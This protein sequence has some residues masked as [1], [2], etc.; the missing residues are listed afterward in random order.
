MNIADIT[1]LPA[2]TVIGA[3]M[4]ATLLSACA[5][6]PAPQASAPAIAAVTTPDPA[7]V[8]AE[9]AKYEQ[10]RQAIIAMSGDYSVT[11]DF[12]ETV[13]FKDGY[14]LK[15]PKLSGGHEVVRVIEDTGDFISLQHT[16]VVGGEHKMPI[17]H[18]RQDWRYEPANVLK[19]VGGN[20]W[21]VEDVAKADR[22]G[23]WSQVVYQVDDAPR[24]GAVGKWT[25]ENGVSEWTPPAE[26]RP[27][28]RRDATTRDDYDAVDAVNRHA[29]TPDGWVHEQDNSKL[30]L[31]DD[32]HFVI[33]REV[34]VNTYRKI[35][36]DDAHIA[37]DYWAATKDYW[38]AVRAEWTRM[39]NEVG[40]FGLTV[41]G[42]PEP[43]YM[44]LL[45]LADEIQAGEKTTA[46]AVIE[47][48][49]VI[50]KFTTPDIGSLAERLA[51][52]GEKEV[53]SLQ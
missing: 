29:I 32:E 47:A 3:L 40:T 24:Y 39:E 6:A 38:T 9:Q 7:V 20:A 45:T 18:W 27:L 41:Q 49:A 10:D 36:S 14:E 50:A 11:F 31:R 8:A 23:A 19:F 52:A 5:T 34:G 28:P 12:R 2:R 25:H 26:W 43:L 33:V 17:K 48:N 42:E 51:S 15:P 4:G 37:D 53:A 35:T 21:T 1:T 22:K 44:P 30:V 46:D 16:L 13:A